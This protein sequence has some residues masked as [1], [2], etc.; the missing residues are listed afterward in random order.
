MWLRDNP[1]GSPKRCGRCGR[2]ATVRTERLGW[3]PTRRAAGGRSL[4]RF[5]LSL[6]VASYRQPGQ[7]LSNSVRT[8][9]KRDP[10]RSPSSRS[11]AFRRLTPALRVVGGIF[12]QASFSNCLGQKVYKI[13]EYAQH[14]STEIDNNYTFSDPTPTAPHS[15]RNTSSYHR[16]PRQSEAFPTW[17]LQITK[18]PSTT[19]QPTLSGSS[20]AAPPVWACPLP[21]SSPPTQHIGSWPRP[22]THPRS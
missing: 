8:S 11:A 20:Q 22:A 14:V 13:E 5:V 9:S 3:G 16:R 17:L 2:T 15:S 19:C 10:L 18:N 4:E 1:C 7:F 21:S 6:P 12:H